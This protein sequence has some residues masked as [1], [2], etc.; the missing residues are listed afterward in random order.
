MTVVM[1]QRLTVSDGVAGLDL[2]MDETSDVVMSYLERWVDAAGR[3]RLLPS[4]PCS[5]GLLRAMGAVRPDALA[6]EPTG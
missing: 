5:M 4:D 6:I 2:Q 3:T 1:D